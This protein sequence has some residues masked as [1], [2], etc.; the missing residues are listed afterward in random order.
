MMLTLIKNPFIHAI[1]QKDSNV[2]TMHCP[3]GSG[4]MLQFVL[5][6]V[7][8]NIWFGCGCQPR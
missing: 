6:L 5:P 4:H 8:S 1:Y 3:A 7:K 2:E